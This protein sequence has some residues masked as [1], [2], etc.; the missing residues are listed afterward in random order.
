M[1]FPKETRALI[2][3]AAPH[4]TTIPWPAGAAEPQK[5]RLYWVQ[6]AEDAE[7]ERKR[8]EA[9]PETCAD[10]LA[11]MHLRHY[12]TEPKIKRKKRRRVSRSPLAGS[13]RILVIDTAIQEIGW[14]AKVVRYEDPDPITHV[15]IKARVPAGPDPL[16]GHP[17]KTET[18]PEQITQPST[19]ERRCEEE[20]ALKVEHKASIDHSAI[21]KAER[22]LLDQRRKGKRS[23]LAEEAVERAKRRAEE[24]SAAEVA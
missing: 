22:H 2:H 17:C 3:D 5:G 10:V 7:A 4:P 1:R 8:R 20:E 13:E 24:S 11:G 16:D 9:S 14:E 21:L 18:E 19:H 15:R 6:S 23:K 12:G